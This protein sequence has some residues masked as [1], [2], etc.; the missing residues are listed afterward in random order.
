MKDRSV[1][2]MGGLASGLLAF[3]LWTFAIGMGTV[4]DATGLMVF[5]MLLSLLAILSVLCF[6]PL[7]KRKDE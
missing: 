6:T 5:F 3:V 1:R 4:G 7:F 2:V